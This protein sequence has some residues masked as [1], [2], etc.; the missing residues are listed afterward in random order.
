MARHRSCLRRRLPHHGIAVQNRRHDLAERYIDWIV[1][2]RDHGDAAMRT[3]P[4][5]VVLMLLGQSAMPLGATKDGLKHLE[6]LASLGA[7]EA[8]GFAELLCH[9]HG[10]IFDFRSQHVD[11]AMYGVGAGH[12]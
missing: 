12:L 9:E 1:P 11:E 8:D 4:D 2:G 6:T 7:A 10:E 5:H 3:P